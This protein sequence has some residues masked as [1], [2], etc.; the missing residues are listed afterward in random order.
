MKLALTVVS[1]ICCGCFA[2]PLNNLQKRSISDDEWLG[3]YY[4]G[5]SSASIAAPSISSLS[6]AAPSISSHTHS[7]STA[8]IDRP[9][10]VAIQTPTIASSSILPSSFNYGSSSYPSYK[11]NSYGLNSYPSYGFSSYPNY[12]LSSYPTYTSSYPSISYNKF[13]PSYYSRSY[14][15]TIYKKSFY[16]SPLIKSYK[17][18]W[19]NTFPFINLDIH[20]VTIILFSFIQHALC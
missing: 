8:I 16:S 5:L 19:F 1:L 3:G 12:K 9:Y 4:G 7:H 11:I 10:P 6:L 20:Y 14:P 2:S 15:T 18:W 13:T 17:W